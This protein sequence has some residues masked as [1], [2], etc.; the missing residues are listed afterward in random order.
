VHAP[1]Y[2][3]FLCSTVSAGQAT[4]APVM[5]SLDGRDVEPRP[6][7]A[8]AAEVLARWRTSPAF[9][10][11]LA[12]L[13]ALLT[14]LPMLSQTPLSHDHPAHAFK[15]WH[16]WTE[17]LGRG[18]LR[19]WSH[20]WG[21]GF[22]SDEL[23][24]SGGEIWVVLFRVLSLGLGSWLHTY[25][26][27][28]AAFLLFKALAAF[29]FTRRFFDARAAVV[30]AWLTSLDVGSFSQ[31]GWVWNTEWGV[32]PVSLSMSL[33]LLG[34]VQ[35]DNVLRLGRARHA[36]C[37]ALF[38][39]WALLAHQVALIVVAVA[40]PVLLLDRFGGRR[41]APL[42][43][44]AGGTGAALLGLLLAAFSIVPFVA[45][46]H[47]TMDLGVSDKPLGELLGELLTLRTFSRMSPVIH[48]LGLAGVAYAFIHRRRGALFVSACAL[49]FVLLTSNLLTEVLHL[50][51]LLPSLIKIEAPRMLLV[52]KLFWFP[53]VAYAATRVY[54]RAAGVKS[55]ALRLL[56]CT[57]VVGAVVLPALP[58]SY[59]TWVV[60]G[61]QGETD[62]PYWADLERVFA[63][64]KAVREAQPGFYRIAYQMHPDDHSST[65]APVY[66]GGLSYKIGDTPSQIFDG[67]PMT[68]SPEMLAALS[69]RHVV[70]S[71]PLDEPLFTLEERFGA[72]EVY[73]FNRYEPEP[74]TLTGP[75]EAALLEHEPE[76]L[77]V[78]LRGTTEQSRLRL[79]V[80][81]YDRWQVTALGERLPITPVPVS[82][83]EDPV[84]M[85]VP[86][87]DGDLL[88]EYVDGTSDRLGLWLTLGALPMFFCAVLLRRRLGVVLATLEPRRRQLGWGL[89]ALAVVLLSGLVVKAHAI[90]R[91]LPA[92]SLFY[93][94]LE[95]S[96][97]GQPCERRAELEFQCG[98]HQKMQ[99][100]LVHA[101]GDHLC[102]AA[103]MLAAPGALKL[104]MR[105]PPGSLIVGRY[106]AKGVPGWIEARLD[107]Q[108]LGRVETRPAYMR[109]QTIQFDARQVAHVG[110]L[111]LSLGGGA[112]RCFDFWLR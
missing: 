83:A 10:P 70:S 42:A 17:M 80:A 72:L 94:E 47:Y 45:R 86:A 41:P 81:A 46:S 20:F 74:F 61:V 66:G 85:E 33:C 57:S 107:G 78:R 58:R 64:A 24:P 15:A 100:G 104:R 105:L 54:A 68:S 7:L 1:G 91:I 19:G 69:V 39:A 44:L 21:F 49:G 26:L 37:A 31:G 2:W 95:L 5:P 71:T 111:E 62:T 6:V 110:E 103:P 59:Q 8:S 63:W 40:L 32:W 87:V 77:V 48:I 108:L 35:L 73:R 22:P 14:A 76:R 36:L 52:A 51:R 102:M 43:R 92:R 109:Q 99:A 65:L 101:R 28:F 55:R 82:G 4:T 27:A 84:L 75:G 89:V 12:L 88:V 67:V 13:P 96:L 9:H 106:D 90:T 25:A 29:V 11:A 97:G 56:L 30:A 38:I 98:P 23:V 18:R 93:R 53:L 60:K 34:C 16:F 50:E 79:H 3:S 112:L